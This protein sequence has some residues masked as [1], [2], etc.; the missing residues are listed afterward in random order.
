METISNTARK[1]ARQLF[2]DV[3][4]QQALLDALATPQPYRP[5]LIWLQPRPPQS[6]FTVEPPYAWQ[7]PFVDRVSVAQRPGRDP[8][9]DAG[10]YYVLDISS[11]FTAAV[12]LAAKTHPAAV[13]AQVD[14]EVVSRQPL[15]I[16]LC[17]SPGGKSI[18]AWRAFRPDLL[19]CNEVIKKRTAALVS[20]LQRCRIAPA[21]VVTIDSS[22]LAEACPRSASLVIVDA[23]CSGQSLIV[24]GKRSPGCFHP[25]TIN[26]NANRQRR[27]LANAAKLV[28]PGGHLAYLTCTYSLKEN[29]GNVEW[30]V[31]QQPRFTPEMVPT[32]HPFQS[33]LTEL[34]CYRLWPQAGIGAGGFAALLRNCEEGTTQPCDVFALRRVWTS[35]AF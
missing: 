23:P 3:S 18:F 19:L 15:V 8:R 20:N 22:R 12:L 34:P 6:P 5:A 33:H 17:A 10:H 35:P 32:L 27:I 2:R 21:A 30:L 25:A 1:L 29:E 7:P 24:K 31:K 16:D 26:L 28:A 9:H 14:G 11:V 13:R 4:A